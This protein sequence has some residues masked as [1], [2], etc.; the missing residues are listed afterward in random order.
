MKKKQFFYL[1]TGEA[2]A[3]TEPF[4]HMVAPRIGEHTCRL[5]PLKQPADLPWEILPKNEDDELRNAQM[6]ACR[7]NYDISLVGV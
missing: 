6:H 5:H 1:K 4:Y 2:R 7:L 3:T